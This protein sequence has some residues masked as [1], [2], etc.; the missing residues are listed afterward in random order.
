VGAFNELQEL[1]QRLG[2]ITEADIA[3]AIEKART[4]ADIEYAALRQS[5][6]TAVAKAEADALAQFQADVPE[7][8]T[9][10]EN[11]LAAV[12]AAITRIL[13]TS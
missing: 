1:F 13:S 7:L 4:E 6:L 10:V 12:E 9:R 5:V 3:D 11:A 8:K 2:G